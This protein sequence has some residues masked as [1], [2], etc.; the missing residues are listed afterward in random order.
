MKTVAL[1]FF[2]NNESTINNALLKSKYG[3]INLLNYSKI[4]LKFLSK[5]IIVSKHGLKNQI[6]KLNVKFFFVKP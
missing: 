3:S 5:K 4:H 6:M 1:L 2:E